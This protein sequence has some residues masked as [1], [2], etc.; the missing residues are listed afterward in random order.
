MVTHAFIADH[1]NDLLQPGIEFRTPLRRIEYRTCGLPLPDHVDERSRLRQYPIEWLPALVLHQI[2]RI[3]AIGKQRETD[4]FSGLDRRQGKISRTIGRADT[5]AIAIEAEYRLRTYLPEKIELVFRKRRAER[6]DSIFDA[7]LIKRDHVHI[8]FDGNQRAALLPVTCRLR[9]PSCTREIVEHLPLVKEFGIRRVH[10]FR[11][12]IRSHGTAA[13]GNNLLARRQ[14]REHDAITEIVVGDRNIR[15]VA[16]ET[17]SLDL[18]LRHALPRKIFFKGIAAFGRI[19]K[20]E[21]LDR[22]TGQ[23]AITKIGPRLGAIGALQLILKIERRHF[24]DVL[25]RG[26]LL[27]ALLH[28]RIGLRHG[29]AGKIGDLLN[30]FRK[31]QPFNI[32]QET[33]MVTRYTATEAVIPTLAVLAMKAR[34]FLAMKGAAGPIVPA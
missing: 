8:A 1:R 2:V 32:C 12:R 20:T 28:L 10:V 9:S 22:P 25:Q 24:H 18:L 27:L 17:T 29:N 33:E 34:A 19:A 23:S 5:G 6:R 30:G 26:P 21:R 15:S 31:I 3:L 13:E 4:R 14:D 16:H 7:R 11:H